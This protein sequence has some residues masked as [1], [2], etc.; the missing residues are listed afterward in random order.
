[1]CYYPVLEITE[2]KA[3]IYNH[4]LCQ[5]KEKGHQAKF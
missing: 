1:M 2:K 5:Q 4:A 3:G